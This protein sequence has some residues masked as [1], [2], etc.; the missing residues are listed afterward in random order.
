M[1]T[2]VSSDTLQ[3]KEKKRRKHVL[4]VVTN[5]LDILFFVHTLL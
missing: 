3:S 5:F 4:Y 1:L 2:G